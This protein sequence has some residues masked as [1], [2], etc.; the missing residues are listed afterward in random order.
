MIF[1]DKLQS[2]KDNLDRFFA[3]KKMKLTQKDYMK[4]HRKASR[5]EE[6][7]RY[8]HAVPRNHVHA[9]RKSYDRKRDRFRKDE[10][11]D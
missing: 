11:E 8:D 1:F 9:S 6:F 10:D 7:E 3:M 4:A 2:N 5:E